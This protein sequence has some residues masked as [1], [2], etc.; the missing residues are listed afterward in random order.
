MPGLNSVDGINSGLN[1]KQI[2]DNIIKFERR[3]AV[4]L[5]QEEK[6]KQTI[7]TAYQ[8]LQA[9]FLALSTDLSSLKK[10]ST[11]DKTAIDISDDSV[12]SASADGRV[13]VGSY[14]LH[15]H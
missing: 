12:I 11:F 8:A 6:Q 3:N 10:T 13:G 15:Y 4:L 5:E 14:N 2:I 7:I 1:T 9:K